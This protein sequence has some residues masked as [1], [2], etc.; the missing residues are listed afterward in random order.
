[1][2]QNKSTLTPPRSKIT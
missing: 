2:L 1:M